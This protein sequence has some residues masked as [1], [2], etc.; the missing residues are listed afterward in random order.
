MPYLKEFERQARPRL[1]SYERIQT[2][3]VLVFVLEVAVGAI[4]CAGTI[5]LIFSWRGAGL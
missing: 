5:L 4:V 1:A 3:R 2:K